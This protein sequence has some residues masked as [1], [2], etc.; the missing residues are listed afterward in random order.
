MRAYASFAV[1]AL[2]MTG[3]G[4]AA[5]RPRG[6]TSV[7]QGQPRVIS[8]PGARWQV[9]SQALRALDS[10]QRLAELPLQLVSGAPGRRLVYRMQNSRRR[11]ACRLLGETFTRTLTA[12]GDAYT[13]VVA[14][15][16]W[17]AATVERV[18]GGLRGYEM[19]LLVGDVRTGRVL[20]RLRVAR[21][22]DFPDPGEVAISP[23]GDVA[24]GWFR[25]RPERAGTV[26]G[27]DAVVSVLEAGRR[28]LSPAQALT[29]DA[30]VGGFESYYGSAMAFGPDG[31]LV[32]A[33]HD[34]DTRLRVRSAGG[35]LGA[36]RRVTGRVGTLWPPV[37][38][39]AGRVIVAWS[40]GRGEAA[41]ATARLSGG[42]F[43]RPQRLPTSRRVA[44]RRIASHAQDLNTVAWSTKTRTW[45]ADVRA[46]GR[47][48]SRHA[49]PGALRAL[50]TAPDGRVLLVTDDARGR[51]LRAHLGPAGAAVFGAPEPIAGTANAFDVLA[52]FAPRTGTPFVSV[53]HGM[54]SDRRALTTAARR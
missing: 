46:D 35:N 43:G 26:Y 21:A 9:R 17:A 2:V 22:D 27:P 3:C 6:V 49:L 11:F 42:A 47:L 13:P 40:H 1:M 53:Q 38:T 20:R 25:P 5:E 41:L 10:G 30:A 7:L 50:A 34:T 16:R 23:R 33:E 31:D 15:R 4:S 52:E 51:P 44:D 18:P 39:P 12:D 14:G 45:I 36:P 19:T 48:S 8:A 54:P 32:I 29:R 37:V 24:V 28:S